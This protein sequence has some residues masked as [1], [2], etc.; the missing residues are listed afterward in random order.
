MP[1]SC[2]PELRALLLKLNLF[3]G[4][5]DCELMHLLEDAELVEFAAGE[6]PIVEGEQGQF[7]YIVLSG[8]LRIAKRSFGIQKV[9]GEL[10]PGECFGEMSLIEARSRSASIKALTA[11]KLLRIDDD[12]MA[13]VPA[14]AAILYRNIAALLSQ[15]LRHANEILTLG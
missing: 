12:N 14:I 13:R 4:L 6:N 5:E 11:C 2:P 3:R 7:M 8:R 10:G 15:R 9:I 1:V